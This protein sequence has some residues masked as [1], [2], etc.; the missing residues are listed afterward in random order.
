MTG[1]VQRPYLDR[2]KWQNL[3]RRVEHVDRG[4]RRYG[5]TEHG[6]LLHGVLIQE[7]IG[8][9]EIDRH[10]ERRLRRRHTGDVIHVGMGQEN[11]ANS[12]PSLGGKTQQ[13]LDLVARIDQRRLARFFATQNETVL[14]EGANGARLDYHGLVIL[15][16][17][18]D[19]MFT[20][21]IK[22]T[23]G[24]LGVPV[25]FV[26][27]RESALEKMHSSLPA[28]VIVDLNG[29]STDPLG[30]LSAIQRDPSLAGVRTIGFVSHVQGDLIE[31]A[32]T[33][34]IGEVMARSAF[35]ARLA[36]IIGSGKEEG[37]NPPR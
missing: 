19:L 3:T 9:V 21:K 25:S 16:L 4:R 27:S 29:R 2:A 37:H 23:A 7:Q 5:K 30:T 11:A 33:A 34:G 26:R 15:A 12:Q 35:T 18:D 31:A 36:E 14:E 10:T 8:L 22:T 17:V 32:R 13:L 20:S 6:A 28:L 24:L 1:R